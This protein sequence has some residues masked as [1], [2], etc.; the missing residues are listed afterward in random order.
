[1]KRK[2]EKVK[3]EKR[4]ADSFCPARFRVRELITFTFAF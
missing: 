4:K 2:E 1:M 3:G